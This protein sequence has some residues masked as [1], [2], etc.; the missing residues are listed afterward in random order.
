[1]AALGRKGGLAGGPARARALSSGRRASI[2]RS[3]ARA[4]WSKPLLGT[5]DPVDLQS[6]VAYCGS[7][8]AP[9]A[10]P[11]RLEALVVRAVRASR[12]DSSLARMLP[13]FLWRQRKALDLSKLVMEA[14]KRRQGAALGFFLEAASKLG[15]RPV[16]DEALARLHRGRR[17][18]RPTYFFSGT[19]SRPFERAAADHATPAVARRWGLLMNMPWDS[20][21]TYFGKVSR[22]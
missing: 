7:A 1:M 5:G 4:R 15:G 22:L 2:A 17:A 8:V 13:V 16:F 10:P 14:E 11:P 3:A 20:F 18:A 21:A 9:V 6:F 19:A 12:R